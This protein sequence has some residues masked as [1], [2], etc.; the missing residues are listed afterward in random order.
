MAAVPIYVTTVVAT[1]RI[2]WSRLPSRGRPSP[3]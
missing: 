2:Y 1:M 3:A